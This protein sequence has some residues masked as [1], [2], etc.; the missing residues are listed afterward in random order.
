MKRHARGLTIPEDLGTAYYLG[1]TVAEGM[2]DV[3]DYDSKGNSQAKNAEQH[4]MSLGLIEEQALEKL[5][6]ML[7]NRWL[8][9]KQVVA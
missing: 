8:V 4:E 1:P 3:T 6:T 9:L 5:S 7:Q 2:R